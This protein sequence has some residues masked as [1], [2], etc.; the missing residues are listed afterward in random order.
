MDKH[1]HIFCPSL[2]VSHTHKHSLS[3]RSLHYSFQFC[4]RRIPGFSCQCDSS[5][6]EKMVLIVSCSVLYKIVEQIDKL[7]IIYLYFIVLY[8]HCN[9]SNSR[10]WF[11]EMSEEKKKK[12]KR[13]NKEWALRL[14]WGKELI[15]IV[16][17]NKVVFELS[18][19]KVRHS[20]PFFNWTKHIVPVWSVSCL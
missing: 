1:K 7:C 4:V 19:D 16:K 5:N 17:Y 13:S 2:S 20:K 11:S 9:Q 12:Q 10:E 18:K 15:Y 6:F 8:L 3:L 14:W